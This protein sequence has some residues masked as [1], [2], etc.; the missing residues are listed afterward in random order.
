MPL[1]I[2]CD[3]STLECQETTDLSQ[4]EIEVEQRLGIKS[5]YQQFF[6]PNSDQP[7]THQQTLSRDPLYL[8]ERA[9]KPIPDKETLYQ[10][11][12]SWICPRL[13]NSQ[14]KIIEEYGSI[15]DWDTS[16]IT[17]MRSLFMYKYHF[18]QDISQWDVSNVTDMYQMFYG[19]IAFNQDLNQ[20]KIEQV[21]NMS[22]MFAFTR[23]FTQ[24]KMSDWKIHPDTLTT[25]MFL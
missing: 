23:D 15:E 19:A 8:I 1:V 17:S 12:D 14:K 6:Y 9:R 24:D 11:V 10:L 25:D 3:G 2:Q 5:I 22:Q 16:Q 21:R 4:L 13:R 18:N 20:W 7:V